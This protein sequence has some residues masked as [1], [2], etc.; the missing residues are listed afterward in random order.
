VDHKSDRRFYGQWVRDKHQ[1]FPLGCH[2]DCAKTCN[3]HANTDKYADK[4]PDS[5][6]YLYSNTD[7]HSHIYAYRYSYIYT[8]RNSDSNCYSYSYTHGDGNGGANYWHH[9]H[10]GRCAP[11]LDFGQH[12]YQG[13]IMAQRGW[14]AANSCQ[15][16]RRLRDIRSRR[17]SSDDDRALDLWFRPT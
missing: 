12:C 1:C 4:Y 8:D 3:T 9:Q 7:G 10:Q 17:S 15:P 5:H 13:N 11:R 2:F 16:I 14:S 6:G